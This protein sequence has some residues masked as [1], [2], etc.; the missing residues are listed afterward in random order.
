MPWGA[1]DKFKVAYQHN[2]FARGA[3]NTVR[4]AYSQ[5]GVHWQD[6]NDGKGVTHRAADTQNQI[7][8]DS[9]RQKY[10]VMTRTDNGRP[11]EPEFRTVRIMYHENNDLLGHPTAW[12]IEKNR[13]AVN[14][15][16]LD[17]EKYYP[18]SQ[19]ERLQFH[20]MTCWIYEGIYFGIMNVWDT[21]HQKIYAEN[22]FQTRHERDV[23]DFY[24]GTCRDG[25]NFDKTWV[26][27]RQPLV[28][29]GPAGSW[30]KDIVLPG[31]NIVT[32]NDEHWIF[33]HGGN[34]RIFNITPERECYIGL[35]K[36]PLD[37]FI[38]IRAPA[39]PGTIVTRPFKLEGTQ[40]KVNVDASHG[41]LAVEILDASGSPMAGF[42]RDEAERYEG[43]DELRLEPSWTGQPDLR[44]LQG[45]TVRLKFHLTNA[46]IYAFQITSS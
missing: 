43:V 27:A 22:D 34:E 45:N 4:L 7:I 21:P 3:E 11:R 16:E 23:S 2:K 40:L 37:R 33:Y 15:P 28:P 6:Y 25:L 35:A 9:L 44:S 14:A 39:E 30:D 5:D 41:S 8:W 36:M 18:A 12:K 46:T 17:E 10:R 42:G 20:H 19:T 13:I 24:I 31:S 1:E 38:G 29:R 26:H 32:Y